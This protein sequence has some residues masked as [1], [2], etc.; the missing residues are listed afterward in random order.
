MLAHAN[1]SVAGR[2]LGRLDADGDDH[3]AA[4]RQVERI[5][6]YL[7]EFFLFRNDV[8][9]RQHGHDRARGTRADDRRTQGDRGAGVAPDRFG[10]DVFLREFRQ[11]FAHLRRLRPRW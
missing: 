6:Q 8:V 1:V 9:R 10:D 3:L 11:L 5:R 7:L 2:R 4:A